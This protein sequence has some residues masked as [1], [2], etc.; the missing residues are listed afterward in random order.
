MAHKQNLL[1]YLFLFNKFFQ[2]MVGLYANS[3]V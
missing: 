1:A 2:A 3:E